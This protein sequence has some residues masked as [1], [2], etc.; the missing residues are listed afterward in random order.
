MSASV[1]DDATARFQLAAIV[2]SSDDAILG[3]TLDQV[4]VSWN[5]A[6]ERLYGYSAEEM[7]GRRPLELVPPERRGELDAIYARIARGECVRQFETVRVRKDGTP[8]EV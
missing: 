8:I 4:V 5:P 6:A 7:R 3:T 1:P 2:E